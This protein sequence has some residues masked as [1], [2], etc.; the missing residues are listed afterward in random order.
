MK[1]EL[2]MFLNVFN[3]IIFDE[4]FDLDSCLKNPYLRAALT[5]N[6]MSEIVPLMRDLF[7]SDTFDEFL[8]ISDWTEEFLLEMIP[9]RQKMIDLGTEEEFSFYEKYCLTFFV[10]SNCLEFMRYRVCK[11]CRK[12][13]FSKDEKSDICEDCTADIY[14]PFFVE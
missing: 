14:E 10:I 4:K 7:Q 9:V 12:E 5:E 1:G 3:C 13:Y 8:E 6:E 2:Y 11:I